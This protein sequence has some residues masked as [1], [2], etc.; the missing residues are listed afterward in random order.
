[1]KALFA[2]LFIVSALCQEIPTHEYTLEEIFVNALSYYDAGYQYGSKTKRVLQERYALDNVMQ[3][4]LIP[5]SNTDEGRETIMKVVDIHTKEFPHFME[6]IRG[7]ADGAEVPMEHVLMY[8]MEEEFSYLVPESMR[9]TLADHCSDVLIKEDDQMI[10]AH[11]EDGVDI[12]RN[13]T[14][15]LH[16]HIAKNNIVLSNFTAYVYAGQLATSAFG[17]NKYIAFSMN[18]LK[19]YEGNKKG[20][21]RNFVTRR[22]LEARSIDEALN[23]VMNPNCFVGHN[24]QIMSLS[25]RRA[26]DVEVAPF[27]VYGFYTPM[28]KRS[29]FHANMFNLAIVDDIDDDSSL[30]RMARAK[31][32]MPA[33]TMKEALS[34]LGDFGDKDFPIYQNGGCSTLYTIH[35]AVYNWEEKTVTIYQGNPMLGKVRVQY[36][37]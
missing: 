25:E 29:H 23:I 12:D 8:T 16:M 24:Y 6:E 7:M 14:F 18:Y 32:L 9:Y 27:G 11:N 22:L 35:T 4:T 28:E 33:R 30:H 34:I 17:Y 19:T 21:G 26:Y 1:M 31:D 10:I 37:L 15:L 2:L 20:W 13:R 5:W 36:K 3:K